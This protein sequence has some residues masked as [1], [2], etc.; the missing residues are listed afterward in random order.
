MVYKKYIKKKSGTICG[1]YIYHS[2]KKD[3]K[4][5]TIYLGKETDSLE[6]IELTCNLISQGFFRYWNS[7]KYVDKYIECYRK[8]DLKNFR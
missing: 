3:G 1:F 7:S 6:E 4:V 8:Q 2:V 5:L